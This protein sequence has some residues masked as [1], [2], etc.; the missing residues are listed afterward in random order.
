[1]EGGRRQRH[2]RGALDDPPAPVPPAVGC[3]DFLASPRASCVAVGA[4]NSQIISGPL[5]ER[6]NVR[7][8]VWPLA[9][10]VTRGPYRFVRHPNYVAVG[11]ELF[12]VPLIH[13]A[14]VTAAVFSACNAIVL[15]VRIREE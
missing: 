11:L 5:G 8:I 4:A 15:A 3:S 13:G 10:P 12:F 9:P 2:A 1:M 7:I 6:W 14:F